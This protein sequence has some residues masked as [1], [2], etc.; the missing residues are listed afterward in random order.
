ME[1]CTPWTA[2][3]VAVAESHEQMQM[4]ETRRISKCPSNHPDH[5]RE[6]KVHRSLARL[7]SQMNQFPSD[8]WRKDSVHRHYKCLTK[9]HKLLSFQEGTIKTHPIQ[10]ELSYL[11]CG[12]GVVEFNSNIVFGITGSHDFF[13]LG[14]S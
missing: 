10:N 3:T 1:P 7:R 13:N 6:K 9:I 11:S 2:L 5:D 14:T 8:K 4:H 12:R